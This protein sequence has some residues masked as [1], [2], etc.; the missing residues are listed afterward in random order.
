MYTR[1][2][3]SFLLLSLFACQKKS[4]IE[5][6]LESLAI[7]SED[8]VKTDTTFF[9]NNSIEKLKFIKSN[10]E[11]I[12]ITFYESGKKKSIIPVKDSQV[13]GECITWFENSTI[14]WKR[15]YEKGHSIKQSINY[16][17]NGNRIKID[18]FTDGS[19]TEFFPNDKPR[20][21]RSDSVYIDYYLNGQT[22][23]SF[24]KLSDSL[25]KVEFFSENG[26]SNF[27]G[28]SDVNLILH[29]NGV[30]FNGKIESEFSDGEISFTQNFI[31]GLPDGKSH[32]KYGNRNI[33][34]EVEFKLGK[35]IGIRKRYYSN[36]QI[37]S[38][39]NFST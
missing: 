12:T 25:T 34:F 32:S 35:E 28:T 13:H 15:Y 20:L 33:E 16:D 5:T 4:L 17:E 11:R 19:F 23:T 26:K 30:P 3:I 18:D 9:E 24:I 37:E 36:G 22:K 6:E 29:K 1:I 27:K 31:D 2:I 7:N 38:V 14:K 39:K 8:F 21:K 10:N